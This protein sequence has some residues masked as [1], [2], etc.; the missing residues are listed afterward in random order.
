MSGSDATTAPAR[1]GL[2]RHW[3]SV[4]PG[5]G[6]S[7]LALVGAVATVLV[8]WSP[9]VPLGATSHPPLAVRAA[10]AAAAVA[11][12]V[13]SLLPSTAARRLQLLAAG[14]AGC[15][16]LA[17]AAA[18]TDPVSVA[19]LVLLLGAAQAAMSAGGTRSLVVRLRGPAAA[20]VLLGGG[21]LL[22]HTGVTGA[23]RVGAVGVG[24]AVAGAAGL[25]PYLQDLDP[26]EPPAASCLV[27]TGF[28]GPVLALVFL[29][30]EL[31]L[32]GAEASI[33][34]WTLGGLG[35][36]NLAWGTV[37]A[38]R[39]ARDE[40]AWRASFLADW[41]LALVGL[42]LGTLGSGWGDARNASFLALVSILVVRFPLWAW[43][44]LRPAET[45]AGAAPSGLAR[46]AP[47]IVLGLALSGVAPF[48]GF[49]VRLLLLQSASRAAWPLAAALVVAMA[50]WLLHAPR[51]A[52][53]LSRPAGLPALG[54][55]LAMGF[56]LALGVLSPALLYW[57]R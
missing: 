36:L 20:A 55:A 6:L 14:L 38:W 29:R 1:R 33:L 31:P 4:L 28:L 27:W 19:A 26:E 21:W 11:A 46:S 51:L 7:A 57:A 8:V 12:A 34:A 43:W 3:P 30:R 44:R 16:G 17:A 15:G 24:L 53:S 2:R 23:Q 54:L 22:L 50:V 48:A 25:V 10:I 37:G 47:T 18:V 40:E 49:P 32:N 39:S 41:G 9:S 45:G 56:S 35:L 42:G 52:R 13:T 5:P